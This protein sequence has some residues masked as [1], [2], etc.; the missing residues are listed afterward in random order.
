MTDCLICGSPFE[1]FMSFGQMPIANGFLTPDQFADEYLFEL[2]VGYCPQCSMVQLAEQPDRE[3]MFNENYAFFSSTSAR[4][5]AHFKHF[6]DSVRRNYLTSPD[7]FVVEIG[8]NDGIMLQ[9]F[10]GAGLRHLGI[11]PSANV[12]DVAIKKGIRT[13]CQFFDEQAGA[14][15]RGR[16]GASGCLFG[17]E[18]DVSHSLPTLGGC[19]NCHFAQAQGDCHV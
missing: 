2:R 17:C 8:S 15:D 1:T 10:A 14:R 6:A 18:C 13:V 4:M 11:E 5:A 16:A 12:G 7:P 19:R 9:H 3:R